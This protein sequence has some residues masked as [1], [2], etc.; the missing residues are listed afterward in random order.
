M[1]RVNKKN[2][3]A[4][5]KIRWIARVIGSVEAL[6]LLATGIRE[7]IIESRKGG[8]WTVESTLIAGFIVIFVLGVIIAWWR[9][10]I[11]GIILI[12]C[13]L[14]GMTALFLTLGELYDFWV[15]IFMGGPFL[16]SGVLFLLCWWR[17]RR[18]KIPQDVTS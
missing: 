9:E 7:A 8:S 17:S 2:D 14:A 12:I 16:F 6:F 1:A 5:N 4:T 13:A 3:R 11:G 15:P 18:S 10:G